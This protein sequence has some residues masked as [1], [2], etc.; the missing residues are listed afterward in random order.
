MEVMVD[1]IHI[2]NI[3]GLGTIQTMDLMLLFQIVEITVVI[4]HGN[5][6]GRLITEKQHLQVMEQG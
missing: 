4:L 3:V 1:I 2:F 6:V 5:I